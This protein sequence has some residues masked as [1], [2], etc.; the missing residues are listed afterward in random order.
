[1]KIWVDDVREA[2]SGYVHVKSV[3]EAKEK[4]IAFLEEKEIRTFGETED[5]SL[6]NL[7]LYGGKFENTEEKFVSDA[8][9]LKALQK[10]S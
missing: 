7:H 10:Y 1:M 9:Q 3:D 4:I 6:E 5:V 8:Q 2:P